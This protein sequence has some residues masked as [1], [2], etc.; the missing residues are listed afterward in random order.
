MTGM[1][2]WRVN[3]QIKESLD[4]SQFYKQSFVA[5]SKQYNLNAGPNLADEVL[6]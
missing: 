1:G 5:G 3:R 4:I 2:E 6:H